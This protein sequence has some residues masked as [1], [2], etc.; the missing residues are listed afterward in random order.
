MQIS[1]RNRA[2]L[3]AFGALMF[4]NPASAREPVLARNGMA[5]AQE[6]LATDVGVAI[7]KT[8]GN[9]VDAAVAMGFALAVTHPFA[10][11]LGGGGFMLIRLADGRSTFI[12]FRE[13]APGLASR[14]MYLDAADNPTNES[15]EGW[16]SSGVPGTVRGMEFA[17]SKYGT[18]K[19]SDLIAPATELAKRGFLVSK[20]L[21]KSMHD[22]PSLARDPTSKRIFLSKQREGMTLKQPEL[23]RTLSRIAKLGADEFYQGETAK[24]LAL[25]MAKHHGLITVQ[26]LQSYQAVERVPL[27]GTYKGYGVITAPPPSSGGVGIL[28]MLHMLEGSGYD[29]GG[30]G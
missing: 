7:L 23:A 9:A 25:E 30:P 22:E 1:V 3:F 13:R 6:P 2:G 28:Q 11:N 26:D 19:W 15:V 24:I 17:L 8:G 29:A 10:G 5:N 16:K 20:A 4:S 14:N 21:A 12:D 27:T 18:R